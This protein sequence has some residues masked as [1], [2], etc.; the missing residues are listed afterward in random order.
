MLS[1]KS[2]RDSSSSRYKIW[3]YHV[4]CHYQLHQYRAYSFFLGGGDASCMWIGQV[5]KTDHIFMH[6]THYNIWSKKLKK[7]YELSDETWC[8]SSCLTVV[9]TQK[10]KWV[11]FIQWALD[12]N[13]VH[14]LSKICYNLSNLFLSSKTICYMRQLLTHVIW[15]A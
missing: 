10:W 15:Y 12:I 3:W 5:D 4:N 7:V 14:W 1:P 13:D 9:Q 6:I 11:N 2:E 8:L